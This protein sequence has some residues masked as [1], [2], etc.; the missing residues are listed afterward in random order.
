[1]PSTEAPNW[2]ADVQQEREDLAGR[3]RR[4]ADDWLGRA[5]ANLAADSSASTRNS[6]TSVSTRRSHELAAAYAMIA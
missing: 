4:P 1:M 3:R 5:L 6:F 2:W